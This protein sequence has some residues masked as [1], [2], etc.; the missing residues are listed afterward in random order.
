MI[1]ADDVGGVHI[2]YLYHCRRQLWLYARGFRPEQL[3]ETVALGTAIHDISY[4]R[5]SPVDLGAA[6]L[7]HLDNQLWVHEVKHSDK[8]RE[9][10]RAQARH[11]CHQLTRVGVDVQGAVLHYRSPRKTERFPYTEEEHMHASED[12]EQ[13]VATI[14]LPESPPRLPKSRCRG[15][16]YSDYCWSV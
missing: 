3:S 9:A 4:A 12:I 7:D 11:Y 2:K 16:S 13:V 5:F 6:T 8:R 1:S 10:D 14:A 15:C